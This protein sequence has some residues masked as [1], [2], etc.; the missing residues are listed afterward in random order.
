MSNRYL[1]VWIE[2]G[3]A[4]LSSTDHRFVLNSGQRSRL[5][6]PQWSKKTGQREDYFGGLHTST[7]PYVPVEADTVHV[8]S[9]LNEL[10]QGGHC[11]AEM[12]VNR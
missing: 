11:V 10:L 2:N 6:L 7:W 1:T 3:S 9:V 8:F 12:I 4:V 5:R